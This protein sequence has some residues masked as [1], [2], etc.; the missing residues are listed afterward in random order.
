ML[1][2]YQLQK[3]VILIGS[4]TV[5]VFWNRSY[6]PEFRTVTKSS[7]NAMNH[8]DFRS[9]CIIK[10]CQIKIVELDDFCRIYLFTMSPTCSV[11]DEEVFEASV[12]KIN[13]D[14]SLLTILKCIIRFGLSIEL[15][16][17]PCAFTRFLA[18]TFISYQYMTV[19]FF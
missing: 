9:R 17:Q 6:A 3:H 11:G 19:N 10:F 5:R 16:D 7:W 4:W 18:G 14:K 12:T 13:V 2:L 15:V 1:E 8:F